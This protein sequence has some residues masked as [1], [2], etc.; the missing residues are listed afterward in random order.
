MGRRFMQLFVLLLLL[1]AA[2]FG[3]ALG[4]LCLAEANP[5]PVSSESRAV[6]V[7]GCQVY[8]TGELSL[9]LE[10][11]LQTALAT[12][13]D[14]PRLIVVCGGQGTGE[15]APEG[16]VMRDW[17]ISRGVPADDVIAECQSSNTRQNLEYACALLPDDVRRVTIITSDYH[18]PRALA[19]ARDIGLEADGIGS[20]CR[21]EISFWVKNH[22][23][24][25]LAWGKY[26]ALKVLPLK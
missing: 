18:L 22:V 21:P 9:Q 15:P 26:L 16:R 11:R 5:P 25:V 7:L 20:P 12:Y 4:V 1:G 6:I 13:Q 8:S 19:L 3:T 24:E 23:R 2:L 10:L 14:H 17:L